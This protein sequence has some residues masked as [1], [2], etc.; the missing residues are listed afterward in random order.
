MKKILKIMLL[1][2]LISLTFFST[3][4]IINIIAIKTG[5]INLFKSLQ[6]LNINEPYIVYYNEANILYNNSKYEE[7]ISYYEKALKNN[8]KEKYICQIK[9]NLAYA[10]IMNDIEP[11]IDDCFSEE[12][13]N[14]INNNKENNPN[15]ILNT[16]KKKSE[17][18]RNYELDKYKKIDEYKYSTSKYW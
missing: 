7:A 12:L 11:E 1:I 15:M 18:K 10:K 17:L 14:I 6:F 3:R 2:I 16:N 8:P 4:I 5:N 9:I 13:V